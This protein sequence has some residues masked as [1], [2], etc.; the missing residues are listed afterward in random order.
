M[1]IFSGPVET[2]SGTCILVSRETSNKIR[3]T[4]S[5]AVACKTGNIMV[6]PVSGNDVNLVL[7][8]KK[9]ELLG[10]IVASGYSRYR[11]QY[12]S[13][14][15]LSRDSPCA[16]KIAE[17][18]KYGPYDVSI[19]TDLKTVDWDNF[20][21][22][23]HKDAFYNIMDK[24]YA[25]NTFIIAKISD[26]Q[27]GKNKLPIC[28]EFSPFDKSFM[29]PTFHIHNG[30]PENNE[31]VDW[32]HY[33]FAKNGKFGHNNFQIAMRGNDY[34]DA[35]TPGVYSHTLT[36]F[37]LIKHFTMLADYFDMYKQTVNTD[38]VK[39]YRIDKYSRINNLDILCS[40]DEV[41]VSISNHWLTTSYVMLT[42]LVILLLL[43]FNFV[44]RKFI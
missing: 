37:D 24:R 3:I 34:D 44:R 35:K 12:G 27:I 23:L 8:D 5:N 10:E 42:I 43:I 7:L 29:L 11:Y 40:I 16:L 4:Y 31:N 1:C 28:Y 32:D 25:G 15:S 6:L 21:K 14:N 36:R 38:K 33:I 22:L 19:V 26:G 9:Y 20:G 30:I 17:I 2:V 18:I 13:A 39:M 41:V